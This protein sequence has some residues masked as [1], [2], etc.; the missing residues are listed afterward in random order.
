MEGDRCVEDR[1]V[2]AKAF[3]IALQLTH[4]RFLIIKRH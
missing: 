4:A 3:V 2:H 1:D